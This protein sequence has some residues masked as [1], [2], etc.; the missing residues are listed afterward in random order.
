MIAAYGV[1]GSRKRLTLRRLIKLPGLVGTA[2]QRPAG[3]LLKPHLQR[4]ITPLVEFFGG[5]ITFDR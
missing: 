1:G 3:H 4:L 2:H 5:N